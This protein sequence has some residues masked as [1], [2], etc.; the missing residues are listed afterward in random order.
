MGEVITFR[1]RGKRKETPS[2]ND[3]T[4]MLKDIAEVKGK[5]MG[6]EENGIFRLNIGFEDMLKA[7]IGSFI[8]KHR[9]M[10]ADLFRCGLYVSQV[11]GETLSKKVESYYV[12]DY[13]VRGIEEENPLILREGADLCSV[14]CIF[15]EERLNWR[16]MKG[17]DYV[18]MGI[19]LYSLYY[20]R[21]K[22]VIGWCMSRNFESIVGITRT[23]VKDIG[24]EGQE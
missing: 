19:L 3:F 17:K 6:R 4:K 9:I 1:G 16:M 20:E 24:R 11:L 10:N 15:F 12:T 5:P 2:E 22:R 7:K 14:L 23:C 21:T 8:I 18:K 13:F